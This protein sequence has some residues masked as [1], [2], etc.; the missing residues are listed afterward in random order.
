MASWHL[1]GRPGHERITFIGIPDLADKGLRL[2]IQAV[3]LCFQLL[4]VLHCHYP[5]QCSHVWQ[6]LVLLCYDIPVPKDDVTSTALA[7]TATCQ[8]YQLFY[9]SRASDVAE[10][11][12]AVLL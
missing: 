2:T 12:V 8:R 1:W 3:D 6:T 10:E 9:K 4:F 5:P 7:L 11:A